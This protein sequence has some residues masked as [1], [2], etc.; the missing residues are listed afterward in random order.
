MDML[1]CKVHTPG[2]SKSKL[3]RS[4]SALSLSA[5]GTTASDTNDG[6]SSCCRHTCKESAEDPLDFLPQLSKFGILRARSFTPMFEPILF[7]PR[8]SC[9]ARDSS[10]WAG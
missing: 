5:T 2:S 6:C 1:F 7:N 8:V 9:R 10:L 3:S 4:V